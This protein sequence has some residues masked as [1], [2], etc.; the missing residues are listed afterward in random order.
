M[1]ELFL[2]T[3]KRCVVLNN[4]SMLEGDVYKG[5][6]QSKQV[7]FYVCEDLVY[8]LV[9]FKPKSHD[10]KNCIAQFI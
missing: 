3:W 4:S 1:S 8:N 2:I 6:K 5:A 7:K 10:P 9:N